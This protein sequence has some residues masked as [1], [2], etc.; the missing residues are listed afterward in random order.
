MRSHG[1]QQLV[2]RSLLQVVNRFVASWLFQ[3]ACCKLF[4]Q[5]VTSLQMTNC[6]KPDFNRLV[7]T[8][9]NWQACCNLLTSCNKPVKL[10]TCNKS[11]VFDCV[12][13][14]LSLFLFHYLFIVLA[15]ISSPLLHKRLTTM[16]ILRKDIGGHIWTKIIV[17]WT[18]D[19]NCTMIQGS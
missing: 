18:F 1:L 11:G 14:I 7:V 15:N 17:Y 5:V 13:L 19:N 16:Q 3:Q 2:T 6:N 8:W 4:Q 9:W 12:Y 10:T